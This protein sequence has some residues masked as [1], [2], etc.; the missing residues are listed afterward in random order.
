VLR[1]T[2]LVLIPARTSVVIARS[3]SW[4]SRSVVVKRPGGRDGVEVGGVEGH[5]DPDDVSTAGADVVDGDVD[6]LE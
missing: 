6:P 2:P 5:S 3:R 1:T 4:S